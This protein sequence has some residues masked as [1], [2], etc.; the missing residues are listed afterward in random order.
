M[1]MDKCLRWLQWGGR[2][3]Y[4]LLGIWCIGALWFAFFSG[5]F[6]KYFFTLLFVVVW[7]VSP[8]LPRR[9]GRWLYRAAIAMEV[10]IAIAF[11]A[12]SPTGNHEWKP[13]FARQPYVSFNRPAPGWVTIHDVRDFTYRSVDDFDIAYRDMSFDLDTLESVDFLIVHWGSNTIAHTMLS[14]GFA[15]GRHLVISIETRVPAD[16]AQGALPGIYKCLNLIMIWGTERDLIGLR[17][18]YRHEQVYLYPTTTMPWEA[19]TLLTDL[20][21]RTDR[22]ARQPRFY[23]TLTA[24]CTNTLAPSM[25]RVW[26]LD[27][28]RSVVFNGHVDE[29]ALNAGWLQP[30]DPEPDFADYKKH[31]YANPRVEDMT[32]LPEAEFSRRLRS[33][34]VNSSQTEETTK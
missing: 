8:W 21:Q 19:R 32:E 3:V 34:P 2:A 23:N 13:S 31:H 10:V 29:I 6:G 20:L 11:L 33:G 27:S 5:A 24:N 14:F 22:L 30:L 18:N 17:T 4:W 25:R 16:G 7:A 26:T 1:T 28:A 12:I 9:Y 15:D